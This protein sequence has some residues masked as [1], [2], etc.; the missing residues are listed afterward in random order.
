MIE[1]GAA[2][3]NEMILAFL[4]A[5]IHSSRYRKF[6]MQHL[7]RLGFEER[8]IDLPNLADAAENNVRESLLCYR[9]WPNTALFQGFPKD[10]AWRRVLLEARDFETMRYIDDADSGKHWV[11]LSDGTRLVTVGACNL[12]QRPT[13]F[14]A[15]QIAAIAEELRTG[16]R[17]PELITVQA[18]DSSLILLEGHSRATAYVIEQIVNGVEALVASS[19][20]MPAWYFYTRPT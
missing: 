7:R 19:P 10:A 14:G 5:E 6:I 2:T 12:C 1:L 11:N 8:L 3:Q 4:R 18:N 20:S 16:Q 9:G 13:D 17:F 15:P